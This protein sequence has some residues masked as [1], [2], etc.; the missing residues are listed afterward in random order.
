M[1]LEG[2]IQT[3]TQLPLSVV[4]SGDA[5][6]RADTSAINAALAALPGFGVVKGI[7]R[8]TYYLTSL[9]I[10]SG[11]TLDMTDCNIIQPEGTNLPILANYSQMHPVATAADA[12]T[13]AASNIIKS[14][15]GASAVAGQTVVVANAAGNEMP[16]TGKVTSATATE[17]TVETL[18]GRKATATSTLENQAITLF[19]RDT[20]IR[21][22]GGHWQGCDSVSNTWLNTHRLLFRHI[23]GLTV[24]VQS[25]TGEGHGG[26]NGG[27]FFVCIADCADFRVTGRNLTTG[28]DG[29]HLN[30]PCF[31][32][33]IPYVS[34]ATGDDLVSFTANNGPSRCDTSGDIIDVTIGSIAYGAPP[35]GSTAACLRLLAGAGRLIDGIKV[36]GLITGRPLKRGVIIGDG[37][38]EVGAALVGGT[39]GTID[40]GTVAAKPAGTEPAVELVSPS[41]ERITGRVQWKPP[42]DTASGI[43]ISGTSTATI[44]ILDLMLD[45]GSEAV[46]AGITLNAEKVT[47][48]NLSLSKPRWHPAVASDNFVTVA[49]GIVQTLTVIDANAVFTGASA[50]FIRTTTANAT[51]GDIVLIGGNY[52]GGT[53]TYIVQQTLGT[54]NRVHAI[55]GFY[56]GITGLFLSESGLNAVTVALTDTALSGTEV[57]KVK[58]QCTL[59]LLNPKLNLS[60]QVLTTNGAT[61]RVKGEYTLE[62]TK[63][64]LI[65][66]VVGSESISVNGAGLAIDISTLTPVDQDEANN[67]N[68]SL[69]CG[70][71]RA[72]FHTGGTGNGW[73]NIYSGLIY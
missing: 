60:G 70:A 69:S 15:L 18:D 38:A 51:I 30:G 68:A 67:S 47:I 56:E 50:H 66:R 2:D 21:V 23:D 35:A 45:C 53:S 42:T 4:S 62:G 26:S 7:P 37:N 12:K 61:V 10:P 27:G 29:V 9:V 36:T 6:G 46:A 24:D 31:Q 65:T 13:T 11:T 34:G 48:Q 8:G 17:I 55:G 52:Q 39:Y 1:G 33:D 63:R 32:G 40:I 59:E 58:S 57:A 25:G 3:P 14:S 72:I 19:N 43:K 22:I 20:N 49:A 28:A 41:A 16:F 71:G 54:I 44:G 64:A 73:K 5:T